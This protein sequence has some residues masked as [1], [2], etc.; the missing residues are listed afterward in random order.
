MKKT[1]DPA[2]VEAIRVVLDPAKS[3]DDLEAIYE[4]LDNLASKPE[5]SYLDVE[6]V[7]EEPELLTQISSLWPEYYEP[8]QIEQALRRWFDFAG[9]DETM[10]A[11]M[12]LAINPAVLWSHLYGPVSDAFGS[13]GYKA[14]FLS[15]SYFFQNPNAAV[16]IAEGWTSEWNFFSNALFFDVG[17]MIFRFQERLGSRKWIGNESLSSRKWIE[18]TSQVIGVIQE[19]LSDSHSDRFVQASRDIDDIMQVSGKKS[20]RSDSRTGSFYDWKNQRVNGW[21]DW[22]DKINWSLGKRHLDDGYAQTLAEGIVRA[23]LDVS[24]SHN[25]YPWDQIVEFIDFDF[26]DATVE[27]ISSDQFLIENQEDFFRWYA[28]FVSEMRR[29]AE[30]LGVSWEPLLARV[31]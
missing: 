18:N 26:L 17:N 2:T 13:Y 8:G 28:L 12:L 3:E 4:A 31:I 16:T 21:V 29:L 5:S 10:D 11:S 15:Y 14:A 6:Y 9:P 23:A 7:L 25:Y 27:P 19:W 1:L 22:E 30:K 20:D 24:K